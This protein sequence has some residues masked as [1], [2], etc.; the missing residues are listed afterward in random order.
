[1]WNAFVRAHAQAQLAGTPEIQMDYFTRA[2]ESLLL[3]GVNF[4]D[5]ALKLAESYWARGRG[6][7]VCQR[8]AICRSTRGLTGTAMRPI[9]IIPIPKIREEDLVE[10]R[11][12]NYHDAKRSAIELDAKG[13]VIDDFEDRRDRW[14]RWCGLSK[15][16]RIGSVEQSVSG[17]RKMGV[18]A[19]LDTC[20][21]LIEM[22]LRRRQLSLPD[23]ARN[24]RQRLLEFGHPV[25]LPAAKAYPEVISGLMWEACWRGMSTAL[26]V[27][28]PPLHNQTLAMKWWTST[29]ESL[30]FGPS[31]CLLRALSES[32]RNLD[33][34]WQSVVGR[35]KPYGYYF[36]D[37]RL[38]SI[39]YRAGDK[40]VRRNLPTSDNFA[41]RKHQQSTSYART[42]AQAVFGTG[43]SDRIASQK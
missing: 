12:L 33:R 19:S 5:Q 37:P 24:Y 42:T 14:R 9:L 11:R 16:I 4:D 3:Q 35:M 30:R 31:E 2:T 1:L 28:S 22:L 34:F 23:R 18:P 43:Q 10:A 25:T 40:R 36:L 7:G 21:N 41:F 29:P 20:E 13:A 39:E 8:A 27:A 26:Q 6:V 38:V 17:E 15:I 32:A